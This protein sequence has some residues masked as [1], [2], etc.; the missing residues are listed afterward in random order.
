MSLKNMGKMDIF[1]V[2]LGKL[3]TN[4]LWKVKLYLCSFF[5]HIWLINWTH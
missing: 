5:I 2:K 3:L 1:S 4:G